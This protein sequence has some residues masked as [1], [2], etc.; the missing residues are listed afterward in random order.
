MLGKN[1]AS[2]LPQTVRAVA[3][4]AD[5]IETVTRSDD[6]SIGSGALQVLTEVFKDRWIFGRQRGEVVDRLVDAG[7]EAG[8]GD[9]VAEDA[10]IYNLGEEGGLR[11]Q[12]LHQVRNI[13]LAFGGEGFLIAGTTAKGDDHDFA[14]ARK[15]ARADDQASGQKASSEGEACSALEE[16]AAREGQ[17]WGPTRETT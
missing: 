15:D 10:A 14:V 9:V 8:G 7:G 17:R 3:A 11:D 13:F 12:L 16:F 4:L 1:D 2:A 5:T 6:P